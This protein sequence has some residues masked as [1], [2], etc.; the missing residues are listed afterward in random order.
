MKP[1]VVPAPSSAR[2]IKRKVDGPARTI[3]LPRRELRTA[4]SIDELLESEAET[5]A[6]AE[7]RNDETATRPAE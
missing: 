6:M 7:R 4:S 2:I 3:E 5:A 1:F